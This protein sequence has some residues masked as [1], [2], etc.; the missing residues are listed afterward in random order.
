MPLMDTISIIFLEISMYSQ[1][2]AL[3]EDLPATR[4]GKHLFPVLS[5]SGTMACSSTMRTRPQT[6]E[7]FEDEII[8]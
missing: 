2:L 6:N 3:A 4:R 7:V 5:P 8:A 1:D